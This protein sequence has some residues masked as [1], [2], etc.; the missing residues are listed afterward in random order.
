[1]SPAIHPTAVIGPDV[2]IHPDASIGPYC[3]LDG[4]V[5]IGAGTEL[6]SHVVISGRTRLGRG[7]RVF[8]FACIGHEPQD[9][10]YAGE[11]SEIVIG[12]NNTI[13]EN[14]TINPGTS[15]GGMLTSLGDDNLLMA[16]AHV[17]HDCHLGNG[18]IL[19]NCATLAGHVDIADGAIIGGLSAVH[20]FVRIGR[21]TMVGGMSGIV[22]DVP[23]FCLTAG[24]YRP[25]LAGLNLIGLRRR[26]LGKVSIGCL[27][28]VY[29]VLFQS[30]GRLEDRLREAGQ[31]AADDEHA[32]HLVE[33]VRTARR[34]LTLHRRDGS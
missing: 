6:I 11:P 10:K 14:V 30:R 12:D 25:G 2:D 7:N 29:K 28:Q 17:A 22:K 20:Q 9:L 31:L 13:R 4:Q 34:G 24:G 26:G 19:A 8:P 18:V 32:R 16:Y 21:Y 3:V 23:P 33:F 27:K 1:V 15:G 5:H